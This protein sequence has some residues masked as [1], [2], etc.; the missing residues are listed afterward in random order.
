VEFYFI[1]VAKNIYFFHFLFEK[2][3]LL[4]FP[5]VVMLMRPTGS[6]PMV[7]SSHFSSFWKP[8]S[9]H[10]VQSVQHKGEKISPHGLTHVAF[11][12]QHPPKPDL[13][14]AHFI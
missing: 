2:S 11:P 10:L 1:Y 14:H 3:S 5:M 7:P 6:W 13:A 8:A 9:Q 12:L 4:F